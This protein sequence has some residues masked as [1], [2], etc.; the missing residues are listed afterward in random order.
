V[1][2]EGYEEV[3]DLL[4]AYFVRVNYPIKEGKGKRLRKRVGE[5]KIGPSRGQYCKLRASVPDDSG[6]R[7][8]G[9]SAKEDRQEESKASFREGA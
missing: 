3:P 6:K 7:G 4:K 2:R 8:R 5:G 1:K 9:G